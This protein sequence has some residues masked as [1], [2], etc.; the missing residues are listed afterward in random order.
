MA[1]KETFTPL[2][3][4]C[5]NFLTDPQTPYVIIGGVASDVWGHL[6]AYVL[7]VTGIAPAGIERAYLVGPVLR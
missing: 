6:Q 4:K 2:F 1:N 3:D 5:I 7:L